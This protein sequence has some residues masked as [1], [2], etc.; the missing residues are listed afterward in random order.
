MGRENTIRTGSTIAKRL[1]RPGA[2]N[3]FLMDKTL[4]SSP[5]EFGRVQLVDAN[6]GEITYQPIEDNLLFNKQGQALPLNKNLQK[7]PI[8]GNIVPL[9]RAPEFSNMETSP[10]RATK[11]IYYLDPIEANINSNTIDGGSS[12][13]VSNRPSNPLKITSEEQKNNMVFVKNFCKSKGL[14]KEATAGIMGNIMKESGFNP[15]N[16]WTDVNGAASYGLI[17]W[18]GA[19]YDLNRLGTTADLQ[20]TALFDLNYTKPMKTYLDK[21]AAD[22]NLDA[23]KAAYLFAQYVEICSLCNKGED[24][25]KQGGAVTSK[26]GTTYN[27][28]PV[29]RSSYAMDFMN[30]FND[31]NDPLVW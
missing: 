18:N 3:A 29:E 12:S 19:S 9:L 30:K 4:P 17:Q 11:V 28:Q 2:N 22:P 5:Y 8:V 15:T 14:N 25:Y 10:D 1:I 13:T 23:W 7:L 16:G 6:T 24:V 27:I 21:V 26:S 31:P 20:M